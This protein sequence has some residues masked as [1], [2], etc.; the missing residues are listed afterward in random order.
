MAKT[1][2]II[3]LILILYS[4]EQSDDKSYS[5]ECEKAP[6]PGSDKYVCIDRENDSYEE[7]GMHCCHR[8]NKLVDGTT[9]YVCEFFTEGEDYGDI[10]GYIESEKIDNPNYYEDIK[11]DCFQKYMD[12]NLFLFIAFL[13]AIN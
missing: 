2:I 3:F 4:F 7:L 11:I 8:T 9:N 5:S 6:N 13:F 12:Y 10:D 1:R